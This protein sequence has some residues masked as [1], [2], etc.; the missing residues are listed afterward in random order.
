[1]GNQRMTFVIGYFDWTTLR[2]TLFMTEPMFVVVIMAIASTRPV[3][4]FAEQLLGLAAGL[5]GHSPVVV[6]FNTDDCTLVG[7]IHNRTC[8]NYYTALLLANQFYKYKPST[9]FSYATIGLLFVNISLEESDAFCCSTCFDGC[10][11]MGLGHG[12]H[13]SKFRMESR[14][15]DCYCKY[16]L[17]HSIQSQFAKMGAS[18]NSG[19]ST[20]LDTPEERKL[21]P[22]QMSHEEFEAMGREDTPTFGGYGCTPAFP[23][24]DSFQCPLPCIVHWRN[25]IFPWIYDSHRNSS[26]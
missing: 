10:S 20:S 21:K 26:K 15:G 24:M 4:K 3:V 6:G 22:R 7:V 9:G 12:F 14:I 16:T 25:A 11:T 17:F 23:G 8:C 1:M 13:G 5:G 19:P 18:A 2:T